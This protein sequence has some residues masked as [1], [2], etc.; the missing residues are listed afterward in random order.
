MSDEI[1]S[2]YWHGL[3]PTVE[4]ESEPWPWDR[5][6]TSRINPD[7]MDATAVE[8]ACRCNALLKPVTLEEMK[9]AANGNPGS[10]GMDAVDRLIQH[11]YEAICHRTSEVP[12]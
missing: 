10:F 12:K 3:T 11:R 8:L 4:F 7:N 5:A 9:K 1:K 2:P 6:G